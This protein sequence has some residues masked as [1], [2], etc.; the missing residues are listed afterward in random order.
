MNPVVFLWIRC[1]TKT[2]GWKLSPIATPAACQGVT[3]RQ[4]PA[5]V[6]DVRHRCA[7]RQLPRF[8][9]RLRC[10]IRLV[11]STRQSRRRTTPRCLSDD[12]RDC[13]S[14]LVRAFEQRH[15][16]GGYVYLHQRRFRVR[17]AGAADLTRYSMFAAMPSIC[18]TPRL[19][20][21]AR[22]RNP[23]QLGQWSTMLPRRARSRLLQARTAG[24]RGD[25]AGA[26][27]ARLSRLHTRSRN[28]WLDRG[29]LRRSRRAPTSIARRVSMGNT[30]ATED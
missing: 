22:R 24:G 9:R 27:C 5:A 29:R 17:A 15:C 19:I 28:R 2:A 12:R 21:G 3:V 30:R 1:R 26:R 20:P 7:D 8:D 18:A 25:G 6:R 23:D 10:V 14:G 13:P 11:R 4:L 16:R